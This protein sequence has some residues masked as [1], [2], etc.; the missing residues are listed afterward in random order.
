M[1]Y[2]LF[3]ETS[4]PF[5]LKDD[6]PDGN[7]IIREDYQRSFK[8]KAR[9]EATKKFVKIEGNGTLYP[10]YTNSEKDRYVC[11]PSRDDQVHDGFDPKI[12]TVK[13]A[14]I[15]GI[16]KVWRGIYQ[17]CSEHGDFASKKSTSTLCYGFGNNNPDCER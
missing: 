14:D 10:S 5:E 13:M 9:W 15:W 16:E 1:A 6:Y 3:T 12:Q 4:I 11:K 2:Y 8:K 17:A 7:A